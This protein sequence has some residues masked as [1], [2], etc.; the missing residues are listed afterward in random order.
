MR[1][2]SSFVRA[3]RL[4]AAASASLLASS[5]AFAFDP[6]PDPDRFAVRTW[7]T[8]GGLPVG[9]VLAALQTR[10]GYVWAGTEEG[11]VRFDGARFTVFN[12]RNTK[13]FDANYVRSL[14]EDAK[15]TLWVG[16]FGSGL[17]RYRDGEFT[18]VAGEPE[19]G[20]GD[21][22][23][24]VGEP[25]GALY[26][27]T[28]DGSVSRIDGDKA[29][30]LLGKEADAQGLAF[31]PDGALWIARRGK[32][33]A[34]FK[35]GAWSYF[36]K[37]DGLSSDE[38]R[39]VYVAHN[40]D[41]Y[42]GTKEGPLDRLT[43]GRVTGSRIET[44]REGDGAPAEIYAM[45][46]DA[47]GTLWLA[48][49]EAGIRLLRNGRFRTYGVAEG[50]PNEKVFALFEDRERGMWAGTLHG[51]ARM[52]RA[53][54]TT[55]DDARATEPGTVVWCVH[56]DGE[57]GILVGTQTQGLLW[58]R[59][60]G[61]TR[62]TK[63][64]GLDSDEVTTLER[65][66]KGNVWVGTRGGLNRVR[67][68]K[69]TAITPKDGAPE[70]STYALYTDRN[71]DL[72]IGAYGGGLA[73]LHDGV[74]TLFGHAQGF[75]I[76][77]VNA[78][79]EDA[80]GVLWV[81]G[82]EGL[83][84]L[85]GGAYAPAPSPKGD[86]ILVLHAESNG[87]MWMGLANNGLARI[88]DGK[89]TTFSTREGLAG[90]TV[91]SLFED[92]RRNLWMSGNSGVFRIA[93]GDA[94]AIAAGQT[95][96]AGQVTSAGQSKTLSP[97]VYGR[98]DGM[99]TFECNGGGQY[100]ADRSK[101]GRLWFATAAGVAAVDPEH[102]PHNDLP[103]PVSIEE[104]RANLAVVRDGER[105][106]PGTR[107]F[108]LRYSALSFVAP[109]RVTFKYRLEGFDRDWVDAGSRRVAYYTNLGPGSYTFR[110]I[111]ANDDG[112]WNQEGARFTF[113]V[114]PRFD[115][116]GWFY[117]SIV[118]FGALG[119]YGVVR[120]R[121]RSLKA[122]AAFLEARVTE[123]TTAL[124]HANTVL[125]AKDHRIRDDLMQ[126]QAFQRRLL[127]SLPEPGALRFAVA[128]E[129]VELV[130]GDIYDVCEIAPGH[131]R[132]FMADTTG[133]G[134]QASLRTIV[135]KAEYDRVKANAEGPGALLGIVNASLCATFPALEMRCS[136]VCFDVRVN[137]DGGAELVYA[138]AAHPPLIHLSGSEAHD[139]YLRSPFLGMM[140]IDA[141]D[142]ERI[143]LAPGD[144]LVAFT[145]GIA[146]QENDA[147]EAYG[148]GRLRSA[149]ANRESTL[150]EVV[151]HLVA[152]VHAFSGGREPSDDRAVIAIEVV[153]PGK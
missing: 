108:E 21:V 132:V 81:G 72:W 143:D 14:Y 54:F 90:D 53:A 150:A 117:A 45:T 67:D 139:V 58:Q 144:R 122:H 82:E 34:R 114:A 32:G 105:L 9:S 56:D 74:F 92:S 6:R 123:R 142:E 49:A 61:L 125:E 140:P 30:R 55:Y 25:H 73:K 138:N 77:H 135:L 44:L 24:I 129:P 42:A 36:T 57:G 8:D 84:T 141:F 98:E 102:L 52:K 26:V 136:A 22:R 137:A 93:M 118:A 95:T 48:T 29:T 16:M 31:A 11:L 147:G 88:H 46:E 10:D 83:G 121:V 79:M 152:D 101:D 80:R 151:A 91:F 65:D 20:S 111:A 7:S 2:R 87:A 99:R 120:L 94:E 100:A 110:A 128:Y 130:G 104:V 145:D 28:E 107:E 43:G 113:S 1:R 106:P 23:A 153:G 131:F 146:E 4:F 71:D 86:F 89:L 124:S 116:T 126:A 60:S 148:L 39:S 70:G 59:P 97:I 127:A 75:P 41:V 68:G 133:H 149:V 27:A 38:I 109:E 76:D 13:A 63:K 15:G 17:L 69:A 12:R 115:Q 85:V 5:P 3:L 35:D 62:I 64:E 112:V 66:R 134:V 40:G 103:P 119:I 37:K 33:L 78:I 51:L 18:H 50:I 47:S 19:L 96:S